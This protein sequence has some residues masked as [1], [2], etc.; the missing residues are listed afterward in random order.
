[1]TQ[2]KFHV[3]IQRFQTG[4]TGLPERAFRRL[5][6]K[7]GFPTICRTQVAP[8]HCESRLDGNGLFELFYGQFQSICCGLTRMMDTC[9]VSLASAWVDRFS[10][11]R[12][13]RFHAD[14]RTYG[15]RYICEQAGQLTRFSFVSLRPEVLVT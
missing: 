5:E 10:L 13:L 6:A 9:Q 15:G 11:T 1:M 4:G 7:N 2:V 14:F 8:C 12:R 3:C